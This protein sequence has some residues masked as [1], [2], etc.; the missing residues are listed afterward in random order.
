MPGTDASER[1]ALNDLAAA[2]VRTGRFDDAAVTYQ[3]A[4]GICSKTLGEEHIEYAVLLKNYALVLRK[5]G[6]KREA[7]KADSNGQQIE[8][9]ANRRNG[10]GATVS[11][12]GLRSDRAV[13]DPR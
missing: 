7:K 2:Y 8:R 10:V 3:R 9:V 5:V 13:S 12:T 1:E 6:R 11:V 4:M